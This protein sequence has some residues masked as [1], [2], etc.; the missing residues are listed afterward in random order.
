MRQPFSSFA[1]PKQIVGTHAAAV[2]AA[3]TLPLAAAQAIESLEPFVVTASL[4]EQ[5]LGDVLP[6]TTVIT[7]PQIEDSHTPDLASL[8]RRQ[9]GMEIAQSGGLGANA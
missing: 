5:R 8:L 4:V 9:G 2:F 6:S 1:R 3:F 7:R